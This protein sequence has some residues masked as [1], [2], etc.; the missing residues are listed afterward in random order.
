MN[1]SYENISLFL[2]PHS[3]PCSA[4]IEDGIPRFCG[5]LRQKSRR[6]IYTEE[7]VILEQNLM[8]TIDVTEGLKDDGVVI[9]NTKLKPEEL[10]LPKDKKWKVHTVDAKT[11]ALKH[12]LGSE[13]APIVN[14]VILGTIPKLTGLVGIESIKKAIKETIP[15]KKEENVQAAQ[16]INEIIEK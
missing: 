5:P 2:I 1:E 15:R 6:F 3:E 12:K 13:A 9:V 10:N 11:V 16:E 14:T 8:E 7:V 4:Y